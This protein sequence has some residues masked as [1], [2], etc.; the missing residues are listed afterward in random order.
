MAFSVSFKYVM[1]APLRLA[2]HIPMHYSF[3]FLD[4]LIILIAITIVLN[5]L[6]M[7][8]LIH[9]IATEIVPIMISLIC[10]LA[11]EIVPIMISLIYWLATKIVPILISLLYWLWTEIVLMISFIYWLATKSLPNIISWICLATTS[12]L[13]TICLATT[14]AFILAVLV[15]QYIFMTKTKEKTNKPKN[16]IQKW[17]G[18]KPTRIRNVFGKKIMTLYHVTDAN[19]ARLI[20]QKRNRNVW[21]R[22]LFCGDSDRC[23]A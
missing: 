7:I 22:H 10:W 13:L 18:P 19:S 14:I 4:S 20:F 21:W 15:D 17:K 3:S 8:S 6:N 5:V 12:V 2:L 1:I 23:K 9:C 16:K 11:T